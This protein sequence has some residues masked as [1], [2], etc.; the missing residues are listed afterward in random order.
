MLH[1]ALIAAGDDS[2]R[3]VLEGANHGDMGFLGD[4][5][6]GLPWSTNEVMDLITGFFAEM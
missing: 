3:Y 2:T 6:A 4:P 1:D 5:L